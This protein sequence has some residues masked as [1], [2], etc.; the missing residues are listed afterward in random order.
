MTDE[1]TL[2][3]RFHAAFAVQ[4]PPGMRERMRTA[5]LGAARVPARRRPWSLPAVPQLENRLVAAIMLVLVALAA[6]GAIFSV[7]RFIHLSTPVRTP[8]FSGTCWHGL[9]M[10]NTRVGWNGATSRTTDGGQAWTDATLPTVPDEAKGQPSECIFDANRAWWAVPTGP[11]IAAD[12]IVVSATSDGGRTWR[13][14]SRLTAPGAAQGSFLEFIDPLHGFL[15]TNGARR[16]V[17]RTSDGGLTWIP[18]AQTSGSRLQDTAVGCGSSG[19]TFINDKAGWITWDC[20]QGFG[21]GPPENGVSVVASTVDG[22]QTWV[23]PNL[24][25]VP[26]S[27]AYICSALPPVFSGVKGVMPV[28]CGGV[29][30]RGMSTVLRT[31]DGGETWSGTPVS[32]YVD[33][34]QIDFFSG[35]SG[36]YF[37][38]GLGAASSNDLFRTTDGGAHWSQV[39]GGLFVGQS[40]A[41]VA[42]VDSR[43]G[44]AFTDGST[45]APWSTTDGGLT[46]RLPSGYRTVPG[47]VS[48]GQRIDPAPGGTSPVPVL[49][50]TPDVSWAMGAVRTVDGGTHWTR[51]SP[52]SNIGA[53]Q[54][55]GYAEFFLDG[56]HAWVAETAGSDTMCS[57]QIVVF[58]TA[59]G[60]A[61]WQQSDPVQVKDNATDRIWGITT[62][63]S[64]TNL[65]HNGPTDLYFVDALHGW[66][67]VDFAPATFMSPRR[68][69]PIYKTVDGGLHWTQVFYSPL[70][71]NSCDTPWGIVFSTPTTGWRELSACSAGAPLQ[72]MVTHDAG[73]TWARQTVAEGCGCEGP[74]PVFL[75]AQHGLL[76]SQVGGWSLSVTQD[77]GNTWVSRSLPAS[78]N[79]LGLSGFYFV[80]PSV[81]WVLLNSGSTNNAYSLMRTVDGGRSWT[82]M[83]ANLPGVT[84]N[85]FHITIAFA[86][87]NVGLLSI[88]TTLYKSVD[89]GHKWTLLQPVMT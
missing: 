46:W 88:G 65:V 47:N 26:T 76:F 35:T 9:H 7:Y 80:N 54:A 69:G 5:I 82:D 37:Q 62:S 18:V 72:L 60:G 33:L 24:P 71:P 15:V 8:M 2:F 32:N 39:R 70:T 84:N 34:R 89:A 45:Q 63:A 10:V 16:L 20:S 40:V 61:S 75:D 30:Q 77:G 21:G 48:C 50:A 43:N 19:M 28:T 1:Q 87:G 55:S 49:M 78:W 58:S 4:S 29:S 17:Y 14:G 67:S 3:D 81:G 66:M 83:N 85:D 25:T 64:K 59:D 6:V 57:D 51:N 12:H 36:F 22:G 23:T 53:S 42:F 41:E 44:F 38:R 79:D 74:L 11:L 13:T 68:P 31:A 56:S 86:N 27:A 52:P 73:A